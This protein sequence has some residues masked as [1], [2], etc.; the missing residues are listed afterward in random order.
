MSEATTKQGVCSAGTIRDALRQMRKVRK[1]SLLITS[2]LS[3]LRLVLGAGKL[4]LE[5]VGV[6]F[7]GEEDRDLIR[8]FL[9]AL[10]WT[11]ASYFLDLEGTQNASFAG[12]RLNTTNIYPILDQ[13]EQGLKELDDLRARV[14]NIDL[15]V[16]VRGTPP[17]NDI[18][19]PSAN[20]FRVLVDQP[21]GGH[22]GASADEA[23]LDEI[24]A[25]WAV[26]DLLD[27]DM[28]TVKRPP[29]TMAVRRLKRS[30]LF[31]GEGMIPAVRYQHIARGYAR[32]DPQKAGYLQQEAGTAFLTSGM[33]E[34][35]LSAFKAV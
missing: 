20:L 29:P 13:I 35:A 8:A 25:V 16:S 11:E 24:D 33:P 18:D 7:D 34:Q 28:A 6:E 10:F 3:D 9:C 22:L 2:G 14:A 27:D 15:M 26:V 30:E 5:G 19:S 4:A 17:P 23:G 32:I 12:I 21:R 1:G 31:A